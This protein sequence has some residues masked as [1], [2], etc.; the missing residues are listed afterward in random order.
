MHLWLK[1]A[2]LAA[3]LKVPMMYHVATRASVGILGHILDPAAH[4]YRTFIFLSGAADPGQ[5]CCHH[6]TRGGP[7]SQQIR[8]EWQQTPPLRHGSVV[9]VVVA[10][11]V[12]VVVVVVVVVLG[13]HVV[14][15]STLGLKP[16]PARATPWFESRKA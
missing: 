7:I 2:I 9:V 12:V 11:A 13:R 10:V 1:A 6:R 3:S 5:K 16:A 4:G 15:A 14:V 8:R